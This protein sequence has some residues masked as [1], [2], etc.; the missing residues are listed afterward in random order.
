M[1][2]MELKKELRKTV[3]ERL[4]CLREMSD[5][6]V[7]ET[8]DEVLLER[9]ELVTYSVELRWRLKKEL[10]DSLRRLDILQIFVEDDSGD[11]D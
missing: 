3:Q 4:G 2:Y 9:A 7:E 6:E 1:E 5:E 11:Y 8:I 10:F